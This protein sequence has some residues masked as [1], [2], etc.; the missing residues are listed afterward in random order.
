MWPKT[1][2][3]LAVMCRANF[4]VTES[5]SA[6]RWQ[7]MR[8]HE[9]APAGSAFGAGV[10][11]GARAVTPPSERWTVGRPGIHWYER[12]LTDPGRVRLRH[13]WRP[14]LGW[15]TVVYQNTG[16]RRGFRVIA[17]VR[18]PWLRA[19][20]D[21]AARSDFGP[22]ILLALALAGNAR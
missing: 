8:N 3:C 5:V 20:L 1:S 22:R 2:G 14:E 11:A 21:Q 18:N 12:S 17:V 4:G 9:Q 6:G 10:A 15:A 13:R 7:E 19:A 16:G